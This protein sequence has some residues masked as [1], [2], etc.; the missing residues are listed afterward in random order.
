MVLADDGWAYPA[1][2]AM[3]RSYANIGVR[4]NQWSTRDIHEQPYQL[5]LEVKDKDGRTGRTTLSIVPFCG[6][7]PKYEAECRA[8]RGLPPGLIPVQRDRGRDRDRDRRRKR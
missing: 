3:L 8:R 4:P 1:E 5:E 6:A 2:P 7:E